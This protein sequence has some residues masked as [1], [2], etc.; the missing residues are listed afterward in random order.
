MTDLP[1]PLPKDASVFD[2]ATVRILSDALDQAW[3]ALQTSGA[4]FLTD[5]TANHAREV[6]ARCIVEMAKLGERDHGRLRDAALA[7]LAEA[8]IRKGRE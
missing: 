5:E 1:F 2:P 8:N 6:L 4:T 3:G 7:H